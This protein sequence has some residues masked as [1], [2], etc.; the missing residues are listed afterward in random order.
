M[1]YIAF[2]LVFATVL[3]ACNQ[4][5]LDQATETLNR[6]LPDEASKKVSI[7]QYKQDKIDYI[8]TADRIERYYESR[9]LDAWKVKIITYDE[10]KQ[11]QSSIVADTAYV[12][13]ARNLIQA[14]GNVI[15]ATPNGTIKSRVINWDR[16]IDEIFCPE[17]VTLIRG[18]NTLRGN[19]LRT[20]SYISYAEMTDITAEG[21]V[22][23]DEIDW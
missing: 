19:D 13:E 3:A 5:V 21:T 14:R 22:T 23:R 18:E 2:L 12:D 10:N 4:S 9:K 20:N 15:F 11:A 8:L 16:N 6:G 1:R 7:Y 17:Q